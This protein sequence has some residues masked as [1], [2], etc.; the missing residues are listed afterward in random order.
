MNMD[1][2]M[3]LYNAV[4]TE[5]EEAE[6]VA[7][8]KQN[9][10]T[11]IV[12]GV[13]IPL[14]EYDDY[15]QQKR[16][17][18]E[19]LKEQQLKEKLENAKTDEA[20]VQEEPQQEEPQE[21]ISD[22]RRLCSRVFLHP[23]TASLE[24]LSTALNNYNSQEGFNEPLGSN[25]VNERYKELTGHDHPRFM[26]ELPLVVKGLQDK[27]DHLLSLGGFY[28]EE[29]F[30]KL[31]DLLYDKFKIGTPRQQQAPQQEQTEQPVQEQPQE[32]LDEYRT[33]KNVFKNYADSLEKIAMFVDKD[34]YDPSI[35]ANLR[36]R[37]TMLSDPATRAETFDDM[38]EYQRAV[39]S[40]F[41]ASQKAPLDFLKQYEYAL[42]FNQK[43]KMSE[44]LSKYLSC[45][46]VGDKL[47]A[48][49]DVVDEYKRIERVLKENDI[50]R[51]NGKVNSD[52]GVFGIRK[53]VKNTMA[54]ESEIDALRATLSEYQK[55]TTDEERKKCLNE[56]NKAIKSINSTERTLNRLKAKDGKVENHQR[57]LTAKSEY[58]KN[59]IDAETLNYDTPARVITDKLQNLIMAHEQ[60]NILKSYDR[61]AEAEKEFYGRKV[62]TSAFKNKRIKEISQALA[63]RREFIQNINEI[64]IT[65]KRDYNKQYAKT[66]K[67]LRK[68]DKK[69]IGRK[70]TKE[71]YARLLAKKGKFQGASKLMLPEELLDY[72]QNIVAKS[73]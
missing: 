36:G 59:Y 62:T 66:L 48:A 26:S 30:N 8:A 63:K 35:I 69:I 45:R 38:I 13:T 28:N 54:A 4:E 42:P 61:I 52:L 58:L 6:R 21:N 73:R 50:I 64:T 19:A 40:R 31:D 51:N 12:D 18:E 72:D 2:T 10:P 9:G 17:Q 60:G 67:E 5:A 29:Y 25:K 23:E 47:A 34:K 43:N 15:M 32:N 49:V 39:L 44:L 68:I 7:Q 16:E 41:E 65:S 46:E 71:V 14:N 11:V 56:I 24:D 33:I 1:E 20:P 53:L 37:V 27:K 22:L 55:A 70:N 3:K 57:M